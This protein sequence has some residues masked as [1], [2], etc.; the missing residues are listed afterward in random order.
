MASGCS[1]DPLPCFVFWPQ[2]AGWSRMDVNCV[3]R[4]SD[5]RFVAV[6][7]DYGGIS[8]LNAPCIVKQVT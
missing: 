2:Q 6:G 1:C 3:S 5:A 8:L 4:T 7:D